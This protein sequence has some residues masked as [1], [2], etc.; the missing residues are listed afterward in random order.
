MSDDQRFHPD[1]H[2]ASHEELYYTLTMFPYP[3]GIGL[4]CGHASVFTINDVLARY[5]RMQGKVVFNPFGFDAFGLPAENYAMKVGKPAYEVIEENKAHFIKQL[6]AL[7]M[8]FDRQ[9]MLDTS[10]P[11]YYHWTQWIFQQLYKAGLVYRD[12]LWVNRCP[13]CQT[14]LANDQVVDGACER[15]KHE[16]VQKKMPQWFIKITDYADRLIEDL[17]TV[18]RPVETKIAQKNRIGRSEGAE[19]DFTVG[20]ETITVFTTRPDTI[21]GVTALVLAPENTLLD[22]Q[23]DPD[24]RG[25]ID[26][27]RQA[28]MAKTAVQRQQDTKDKTGVFSGLHAVH[29]L[30]G[31]EIP[32]RY[33]DYV[34]PDYAT[35]SVMLVPA[36]DERDHE[37]ATKFEIP[38]VQVIDGEL[39]EDETVIR[40]GVLINSADFDGLS[41]DEAQKQIIDHLVETGNG[42]RKVTYKLRD[43]S[44]SRQRYRGSPIPVYYD[45]DGQP[46]LIPEA[47]LPVE[48]PLDVDNYQPKGKSPLADHPTFPAVT[49]DGED[50]QRECDTLDTF[51]CSSFYFLRYPDPHNEQELADPTLLNKLFPVDIYTGGK[52][53][54]VGHLLYARFIHKFLYDQGY[55]STPEPF[56]KLVHQGMV[57][58]AD[59][60]KMGKRYGNGVDPIEMIDL[61]GADALRTYLMFMGPIEQDKPRNDNSLKGVA[62]FLKRVTTLTDDDYLVDSPSDAT[63]E[64]DSL[65]HKTIKGVTNDLEALKLN[66]VV[67]KLMIFINGVYEVGEITVQQL[68]TFVQLLAP[69]A[70]ELADELW[71]ELGQEVDVQYTP[72][73]RRDEDKI[74]QEQ[75]DLPVQIN[76]KMRGTLSVPTGLSED[77]VVVLAQQDESIAKHLGDQEIKK[78]IYVQDK[79]LNIVVG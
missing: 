41:H 60:R 45:H 65:L 48:L 54:T 77:E 29:P 26:G 9:R 27:Y 46:Q 50:Y 1:L 58:G 57:L 35:G 28:T 51:M 72:W 8:S 3:S 37:F 19:I 6:K 64:L 2:A 20:D 53:H 42:R 52:E 11:N 61:Y 68:A 56:A 70:P 30:T 10:K 69:F 5:Q 38:I 39:G 40:A 78:V 21:Y 76:G 33:A 43:W 63:R 23:L 17:E 74:A 79:I 75:L 71:E 55:V 59:G 4:H 14:V 15:C 31:K 24:H 36:H 47:D 22:E 73:P 32:V 62:K 7:N 12:T 25:N 67:S 16:I 49:I 44:V 18:D 13:D 34:L 66:T